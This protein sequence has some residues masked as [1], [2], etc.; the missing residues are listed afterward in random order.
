MIAALVSICTVVSFV[1]TVEAFTEAVNAGGRYPFGMILLCL[2]L[3][4]CTVTIWRGV[5]NMDE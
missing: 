2:A 4:V 1:N 3:A 5:R